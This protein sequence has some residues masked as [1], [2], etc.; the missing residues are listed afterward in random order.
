MEKEDNGGG[1][2][3]LEGEGEERKRWDDGIK[4]RRTPITP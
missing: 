1:D 3:R 2:E 4:R